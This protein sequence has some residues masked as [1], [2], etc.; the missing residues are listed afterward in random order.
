MDENVKFVREIRLGT[1]SFSKW[2]KVLDDL[3]NSDRGVQPVGENIHIY[4]K[5]F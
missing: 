3:N 1:T 4:E 5:I 2:E